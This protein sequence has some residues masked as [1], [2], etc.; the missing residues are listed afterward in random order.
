MHVFRLLIECIGIIATSELNEEAFEAF[1][2]FSPSIDVVLP[3]SSSIGDIWP[4]SQ[5]LVALPHGL[6]RAVAS[7]VS[8]TYLG[9]RLLEILIECCFTSQQ[10][11]TNDSTFESMRPWALNSCLDLWTTFTRWTAGAERG[12]LHDD[13]EALYMQSLAIL[14]LPDLDKE[15]DFSCSSK[16]LISFTSG[17]LEGLRS[18]L[19]KPF[20]QANQARLGYVLIRLQSITQQLLKD[21]RKGVIGRCVKKIMTDTL[22][23]D[24]AAICQTVS[25]LIALEKDL[26]VCVGGSSRTLF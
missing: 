20:S 25:D 7:Q 12:P 13:I 5:H 18:C 15:D 9:F 8:A 2:S 22:I 24:I 10:W 23:P 19:S 26:Q 3:S 6:Q 16:A 1:E 11:T 21:E 14:A 4:E 17:L